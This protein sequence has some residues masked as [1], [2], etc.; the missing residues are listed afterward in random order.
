MN[1]LEDPRLPATFPQP[2]NLNRKVKWHQRVDACLTSV[3]AFVVGARYRDR[4]TT[5]ARVCAAVMDTSVL[6]ARCKHVDI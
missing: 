5:A 3:F 1:K 2:G 6:E 4:P